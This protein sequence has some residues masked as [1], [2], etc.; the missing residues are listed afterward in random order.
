ML[1]QFGEAPLQGRALPVSVEPK[2]VGRITFT[3]LAQLQAMEAEEV[4]PARGIVATGEICLALREVEFELQGVRGVLA[5]GAVVVEGPRLGVLA[6]GLD[7]PMEKDAKT[8]VGE[9][10]LARGA[11]SAHRERGGAYWAGSITARKNTREAEGS[12]ITACSHWRP[13][14]AG[15]VAV[16]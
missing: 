9:P 4:F 10:G 15:S 14:P 13:G 1:A 7:A 6:D 16:E 11:G 2:Q 5:R 12:G 3:Q 8:R